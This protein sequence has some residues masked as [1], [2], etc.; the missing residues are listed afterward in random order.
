MLAKLAISVSRWRARRWPTSVC[1][2]GFFITFVLWGR[3]AA[4]EALLCCVCCQA[5]GHMP[6]TLNPKCRTSLATDLSNGLE[7]WVWQVGLGERDAGAS[8]RWHVNSL[9]Q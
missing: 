4:L 6:K 1:D 5:R 8:L 7:E 2:D 3:A 9:N